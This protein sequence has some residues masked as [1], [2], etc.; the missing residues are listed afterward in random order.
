V[1]D[2]IDGDWQIT[3]VDSAPSTF[4][5]EIE[6]GD[7]DRDGHLE[8]YATPSKPNRASG[9][10]QPGAVLQFRWDGSQYAR[11]VVDSFRIPMPRRSWWLISTGTATS[12]MSSRKR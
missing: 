3:V 11:T 8:F 9:V 10:S 6:I 2:E 1:A 5:H 7:L 12:S 4:V